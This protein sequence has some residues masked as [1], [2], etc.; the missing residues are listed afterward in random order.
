MAAPVA[1]GL[2][3]DPRDSPMV[4]IRETTIVSSA[5]TIRME[6]RPL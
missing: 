2:S 3:K 4:Q 1:S 6:I 5:D